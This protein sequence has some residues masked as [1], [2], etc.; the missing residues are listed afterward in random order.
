MIFIMVFFGVF[1]FYYRICSKYFLLKKFYCIILKKR[2]CFLQKNF[3]GDNGVTGVTKKSIS[4]KCVYCCISPYFSF[5][6]EN[7]HLVYH[8]F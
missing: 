1:N 5:S 8:S 3:R 2:G 7:Q 6:N 4:G